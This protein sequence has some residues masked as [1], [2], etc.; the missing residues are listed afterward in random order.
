MRLLQVNYVVD[1]LREA[2]DG[3]LA[4]DNQRTFPGYVQAINF[5][6][7]FNNDPNNKGNTFRLIA[8]P[9]NFT[10]KEN[11][12]K[13]VTLEYKDG[14]TFLRPVNKFNLELAEGILIP[15]NSVVEA[16][17]K[18]IE[19]RTVHGMTFPPNHEAVLLN[20]DNSTAAILYPDSL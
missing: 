1:I 5:I 4:R 2:S 16:V 13:E 6:E 12:S 17:D 18:L 11:F 10:L 15:V 3:T 9:Y 20:Q 19:F 8:K 14:Q 7:S